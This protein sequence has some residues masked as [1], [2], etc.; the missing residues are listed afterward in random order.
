MCMV[1]VVT[2]Y[3]QQQPIEHWTPPRWARFT[4]IV[5]GARRLDEAMG[6]PDCEDPAKGEWM[7]KVE[8]RLAEL[9]ADRGGE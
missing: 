8:K 6:A 7:K 9:K 3:G 2:L 4:Q 5:E 1:S